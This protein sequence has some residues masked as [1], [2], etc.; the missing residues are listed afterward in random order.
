MVK[1]QKR[2]RK[3]S[4]RLVLAGQYCVPA[5]SDADFQLAGEVL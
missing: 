4:E 1:N 3:I 2:I 5:S